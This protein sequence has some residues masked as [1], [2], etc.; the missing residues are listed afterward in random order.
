MTS[1]VLID[2]ADGSVKLLGSQQTIR[3]GTNQA[4]LEAMLSEYKAG[5]V[6]YGNGCSWLYL[7]DLTFGEMPCRLALLFRKKRL[8]EI[9]F[10]VALPN[11][12]IECGW[13]TLEAINNE[14]AFVR[15]VFSAQLKRR[16]RSKSERFGWGMVWSDYDE[17]G[18]RATAGIRYA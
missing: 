5:D 1:S 14:I 4:D 11:A 3:R 15:Q 9:H 10:A 7:H 6:D 16:V 13:P 18:C 8:A 2:I 17:K 12:P